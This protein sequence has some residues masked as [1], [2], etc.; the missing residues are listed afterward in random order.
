MG[1]EGHDYGQTPGHRFQTV[2]PMG[3]LHLSRLQPGF[4]K[5]G[6][7]HVGR[8]MAMSEDADR[9]ARLKPAQ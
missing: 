5:R 6:F 4:S 8:R 3:I 1:Q 9:E 7:I 2:E